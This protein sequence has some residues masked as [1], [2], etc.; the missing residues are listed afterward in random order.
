MKSIKKTMM[1]TL[2]F[3]KW[4]NI[5]LVVISLIHIAL[6]A[7]TVIGLRQANSFINTLLNT[8]MVH[9][10]SVAQTVATNVTAI[11]FSPLAVVLVFLTYFVL[12]L[13]FIGVAYAV[14]RFMAGEKSDMQAALQDDNVYRIERHSDLAGVFDGGR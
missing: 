4:F 8:I 14:L 13:V 2:N 5:W 10:D 9:T 1:K 11:Y 7:G 3:N 12:A 6:F